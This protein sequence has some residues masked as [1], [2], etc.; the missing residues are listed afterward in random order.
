MSQPSEPTPA[1]G[2]GAPGSGPGLT[3]LPARVDLPAL[4]HEIMTRWQDRKVFRRS[5]DQTAGGPLWTF[6][7]GPPTAN[8]KPGTHHVEARVFKDIFPRFK[9]MKG[10]HVPR[11]GGWDCHGLPV[12]IAVEQELG[13]NGKPDIERYGVA[14]FNAKCRESV[15][16]HVDEFERVTERMGFWVDTNEAYRT[17]DPDYIESVWWSLKVIWDKGLLV[18]DHRVAPYCP[19]CGT[20]LSDHEVAQGYE[21]VVDP[22]VYVR[23]PVTGGLAAAQGADLLVWTTTPWT[24]VSN[25]AVA[26]N[27]GVQYVTARSAAGTF[28]VAEPLARKVL[29]DDVEIL[30]AFPGSALERTTYSRP[31]DFVEIPGAHYVILADYVT[32]EDG[33]GLVHQSPAFG[34]EDLAAVREYGMPVV[35]PIETDGHFQAGLPLVGGMFFKKA[36]A[37]LV[38]DLRERGLLFREQPYEHAYPHCWR[39]HTPLMYYALPSWYIRTTAVKDAMLRENERTRWYPDNVKHGRYGDWLTNNVDWA[40]SRDRYWGTPLPIWRC[41]DEHLTCVG[42]LAEL[43]LLA[44]RDLSTLDPHR[45]YVDDVVLSCPECGDQARRVPQVIDGWYDSGSM[46]FAQWG[47]PYRNNDAFRN[48]YPAQYICEAIDQTRGWFYSLMAVGT[49]VFDQSSYETVLCLGHIL[50]EDGRKMSKHLGNI[51]EPIPLMD[52][53]GADAVRWF[54]LCS[55]S[56]WSARRVG[57]VA[58]EEIVRKLLLTYWNTASFL[59]LYAN[60]S[61]F[62]PGTTPVPAVASRPLL[63]RW[64]LSELHRTVSEVDAALEDFDPPRAGRRI[65]EFVDDLSNWYVRRSRRR[66]WAGDA[67]ALGTL[68]ECLEVLTRLLAPF[69]PFIT[70]AVHEALVTSIWPD[71]PNSVH[72]RQWPVI[73]ADGGLYDPAL[74]ERMALVRRLVELG[75]SARTEAKVRTRQPLGRALVAAPGW[76][77]LPAELRALIADELNVASVDALTEQA[78]AGLVDVTVKPQF[79]A[80]GQRFGSRTKEVAAALAAADPAAVAAALRTGSADIVLGD[81]TLTLTPAEVVVTETPRSGW[82]VVAGAGETI[83]LDLTITPEL[84][85]AGLARE[86]IRLI[87]D[88]RKASGLEITD[89][90]TLWWTAPHDL[91]AALRE[92]AALVAGEVLATSYTE[93]DLPPDLPRHGDEDLGLTFALSR[94]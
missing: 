21:T 36:D 22:S 70:E 59:T 20:G 1:P 41:A 71:Q 61:G 55:G 89:R 72:L 60:A 62:V 58:L 51:L 15:E 92:H 54:M 34:A 4:E 56:P 8:G 66:F 27:P 80:L 65:A 91:A 57:H 73:G 12:E 42:S 43:G 17:M 26:V 29:G 7:E 13:F 30:A 18:Q 74:S 50:A 52:R 46:P 28:V 87:Q 84:R 33:S 47:A 78:G 83:A 63:D 40:L 9:T 48:A 86:A 11:K 45:P 69:T 77:D 94:A 10:F 23:F 90:I 88:A 38:D 85:R 16:R 5:L 76:A 32:T 39:C 2:S 6:Y 75:R 68:H 82:A 19:R 3:P 79:R 64:A 35:N 93:G 37:V 14:E 53:H 25:T 81:E 49:L 67:G 31:F 44:G 24:L